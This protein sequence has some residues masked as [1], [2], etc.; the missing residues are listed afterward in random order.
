M[1]R[2]FGHPVAMCCD[3]LDFENRISVRARAQHVATRR[4]KVAKLAQHAA[5]NNDAICCFERLLSFGHG[6]K[7][8]TGLIFHTRFEDVARGDTV[9]LKRCDRLT[10]A[11]KCWVQ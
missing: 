2:A 8:E 1:L 4:N 9:V 5:T 7:F 10:G 6:F 11:C 3:G